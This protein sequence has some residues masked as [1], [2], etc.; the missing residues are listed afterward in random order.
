[1]TFL[2][3]YLL[4]ACIPIYPHD[5]SSH[6]SFIGTV[7]MSKESCQL[8]SSAWEWEMD[9]AKDFALRKTGEV[10]EEGWEYAHDFPRTYSPGKGYIV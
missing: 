3:L 5:M 6:L 10:D 8:P 2:S 4:M 9:W 1:M 7:K